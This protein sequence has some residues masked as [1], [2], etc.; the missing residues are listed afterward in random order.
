MNMKTLAQWGYTNDTKSSALVYLPD[1]N[2]VVPNASNYD[3]NEHAMTICRIFGVEHIVDDIASLSFTMRYVLHDVETGERYLVAG[4]KRYLNEYV[5]SATHD[6]VLLV[7]AA[8][9]E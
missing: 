9:R 2:T 6:T 3:Y 8:G 5:I 7:L 4:F 1:L